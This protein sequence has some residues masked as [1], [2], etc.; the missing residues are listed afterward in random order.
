MFRIA[1]ALACVAA[2]CGGAGSSRSADLVRDVRGY[3]EGLRWRDFPTAALRVMPARREQF[4]DQ[5]EKLDEDLRVVDWEMTRLEYE[6]SNNRARVQ[7]EY[8]WLLDSRG[9]VHTTVTR[10]SWSRHGDRWMLRREVRVRGEPMPGVPEPPVR[11]EETEEPDAGGQD[12]G[13]TADAG[14]NEGPEPK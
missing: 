8:R 3:G 4:L 6:S 9:I 7:I 5:R 14:V 12:S 13:N 2:G 1:A 10:Q 11:K